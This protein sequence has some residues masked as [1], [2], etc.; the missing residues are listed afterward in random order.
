M[1]LV[2]ASYT[3]LFSTITSQFMALFYGL[4]V[5]L[6]GYSVDDLRIYWQS[7]SGVARLLSKSLYY[8]LPDLQV[9]SPYPVVMGRERVPLE[10]VAPLVLY[11]LAYI[12][13]PIAI[14]M[15]V[16]ERREFE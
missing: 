6:I 5:M 11:A 3:V 7:A 12:V 4:L 9:F 14:G 2:L 8:I 1:F 16:L 15:L 13:I 10:L